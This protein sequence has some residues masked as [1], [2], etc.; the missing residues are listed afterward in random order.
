MRE[1]HEVDHPHCWIHRAGG[2]EL[3]C[4]CAVVLVVITRVRIATNE[5]QI[6]AC[7]GPNGKPNNSVRLWKPVAGM[8]IHVHLPPLTKRP[9][10]YPPCDT[11][12]WWLVTVEDSPRITRKF[13]Q[14]VVCEHDV[15]MD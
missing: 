3:R 6:R 13:R 1:K 12:Y 10:N 7:I 11:R 8:E 4:A 9:R 2:H 5:Q 15:E 14:A